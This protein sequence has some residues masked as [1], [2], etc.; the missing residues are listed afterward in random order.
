MSALEAFPKPC[1]FTILSP[2]FPERIRIT[3]NIILSLILLKGFGGGS[4]GYVSCSLCRHFMHFF[5]VKISTSYDIKMFHLQVT[6]SAYAQIYRPCDEWTLCWAVPF[7]ENRGSV[8]NVCPSVSE[9]KRGDQ[10]YYYTYK[11]A[12]FGTLNNIRFLQLGNC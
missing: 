5:C 6:A 7:L 3:P 12:G 2:F 1:R 11:L 4:C 9:C 8:I 10:N